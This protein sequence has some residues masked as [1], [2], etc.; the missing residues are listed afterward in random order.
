[1]QGALRGPIGGALLFA[2]LS[3][4]FVAS[5]LDRLLPRPFRGLPLLFLGAIRFERL[6]AALLIALPIALLLTTALQLLASSFGF[7]LRASIPRHRRLRSRR[8]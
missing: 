5:P 1:L 6:P 4:S 8:R 7:P 2:F 3:A